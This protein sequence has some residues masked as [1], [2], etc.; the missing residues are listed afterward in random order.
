MNRPDTSRLRDFAASRFEG[1]ALPILERYVGIPC[2]S[3]LFDSAWRERGHIEEAISLVGDWCRARAIEGLRVERIQLEE[4]TPVLWMEIPGDVDS[5]VL[6]YGHLDKQPEMEGWAVD[7]GPW[8]P[9]RRGEKLYGRGAADDGYAAFASLLAVESLSHLGVPR[10]RCV[11]LIEASE[12]SGS[13]DLPAYVEHL[14]DRIGSPELVICLDSGC[15]DYDH[16]WSTTSLRG[17][18]TG[19]LEVEVLSEGVHSG[20]AGGVVPDSFRLLRTLLERVEEAD[21]GRLRLPELASEIPEERLRQADRAAQVLGEGMAGRFPFVAGARPEKLD[22]AELVLARSWGAALAVTGIEGAP[23]LRD[24]GNVLRPRTRLKLSLRLPP[25]ADPE[26]AARALRARLE[27]QPPHGA[28]VAF[29]LEGAAA[30]W[31]APPLAPWLAEALNRASQAH[32]G[33]PAVH[34]GEGGSIPFMGMLG[35]RFP[36]A[37]F[38]ITGVLGPGSNA[39]GPNEFLHVPTAIRLTACVASVLADLAARVRPTA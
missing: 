11:V 33:A 21:S 37:Q 18:L 25:T 5:T 2:K 34:M 36:S 7:L 24:A 1:E 20:D 4:R 38:L 6:L 32:F 35:A 9:V 17:M 12:E 14:A 13:V 8:R 10:P 26:A 29:Q 23:P 22:P 19:S 28:R 27:D 30:G 39:H 31:N 16:L 15:G 3:P